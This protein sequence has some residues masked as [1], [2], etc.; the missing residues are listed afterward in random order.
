MK[1]TYQKPTLTRRE[2]LSNVTAQE[3]ISGGDGLGT[4]DHT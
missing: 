1:K 3:I 4:V 2:V